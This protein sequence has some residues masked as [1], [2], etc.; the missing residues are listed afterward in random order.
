MQV[1]LR[2]LGETF[3]VDALNEGNRYSTKA[4]RGNFTIQPGTY[5]LTRSGK[6]YKQSQSSLHNLQLGEFVAPQPRSD[7]PTVFHQPKQEVTANKSLSINAV[8]A[9]IASG[10]KVTLLM[11]NFSGVWKTIEMQEKNAYTWQAEVPADILTPGLVQYRISVQ[12]GQDDYTTFPGGQKGN[13]HAWDFYQQDYWQMRVAA[14][15]SALE[16]FNAA[17][18]RNLVVF[19]N[20]WRPEERQLITTETPGQMAIRLSRPNLKEGEPIIAW[21]HFVGDKLQNRQTELGDFK[22]IVVKA[23][24]EKSAPLQ[25]KVTLI[26]KDAAAYSAT[27]KLNQQQQDIEIPLESLR[28]D[29]F[30]LLPRPYPGF[31]PF[32]FKS[33][34]AGKFDL[35]QVEKIEISIGEGIAPEAFGQA[36]TFEVT[37]IWLMR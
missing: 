17:Q 3:T 34:S 27:V 24:T 7:A 36:H 15:N 12:K 22:R 19:P 2:D 13:P 25:M 10:D 21:Q 8:I 31:H 29:S 16:L 4:S 33:A 32:R 18:D 14:E 6:R 37:S 11:N 28:P 26:T 35:S 30:I 9:G 20:L 1:R 5:L 23:R